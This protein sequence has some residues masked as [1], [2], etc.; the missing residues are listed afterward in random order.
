VLGVRR[1]G[2]LLAKHFPHAG[3]D[4]DELPNQPV[5]L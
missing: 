5:L 3:G 4:R 1:I 2:E